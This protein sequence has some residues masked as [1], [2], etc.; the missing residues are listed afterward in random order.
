M[1]RDKKKI[2]FSFVKDYGNFNP[3]FELVNPLTHKVMLLSLP[4]SKNIIIFLSY[5]YGACLLKRGS[6]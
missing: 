2:V 6:V 4:F 5:D 1:E 3:F